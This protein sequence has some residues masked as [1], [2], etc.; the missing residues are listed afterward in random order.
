M[1]F[2]TT[3]F[4]RILTEI[5]FKWP[6]S[7]LCNFQYFPVKLLALDTLSR[8]TCHLKFAVVYTRNRLL[9]N[10][11]TL[12]PILETVK[13]PPFCFLRNLSIDFNMILQNI[14]KMNEKMLLFYKSAQPNLHTHG[15]QWI[16]IQPDCSICIHIWDFIVLRVW[17]LSI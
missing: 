10:F 1:H 6:L 8:L 9:N 13:C 14:G 15:W 5:P 7:I 3:C 16:V 17:A 2:I 12:M 11:E 4:S